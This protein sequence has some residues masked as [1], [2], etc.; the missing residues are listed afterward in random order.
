MSSLRKASP[1]CSAKIL[2]VNGIETARINYEVSFER[3]ATLSGTI[4]TNNFFLPEYKHLVFN[5]I[6]KPHEGSDKTLFLLRSPEMNA[7]FDC[8]VS[9]WL[10]K[11]NGDFYMNQDVDLKLKESTTNK[12]FEDNRANI[13]DETNDLLPGGILTFCCEITFPV[14]TFH[15][16]T[17]TTTKAAEAVVEAAQKVDDKLQL[18]GNLKKLLVAGVHA[19]FTFT[20]GGRLFPV[21]KAILHAQSAYFATMFSH[22]NIKEAMAGGSVPIEDIDADLFA[23]LLLYLY[24]G[25]VPAVGDVPRSIELLV[26]ADRFQLDSLKAIVEGELSSEAMLTVKSMFTLLLSADTYNASTLKAKTMEFIARRA[27]SRDILTALFESKLYIGGSGGGDG[28]TESKSM[29]AVIQ[30]LMKMVKDH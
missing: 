1:T 18:V 17:I 24:T 8:S 2:A 6:L 30:D 14:K 25:A 11:K 7:P 20:V 28:K 5:L 22:P 15:Q 19:D 16:E 26:A 21:H 23:E 4:Y 9:S 12:V 29:M 27:T 10:M 3:F 13:L